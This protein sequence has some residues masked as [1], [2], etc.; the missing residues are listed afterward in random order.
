MSPDDESGSSVQ[1]QQIYTP[2]KNEKKLSRP[3]EERKNTD[4][5]HLFPNKKR[6]RS[7]APV[8]ANAPNFGASDKTLQLL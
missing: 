1:T 5:T 6:F 2:M 4:I 3:E 8:M 7:I